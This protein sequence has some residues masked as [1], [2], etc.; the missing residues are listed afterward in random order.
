MMMLPHDALEKVKNKPSSIKSRKT[1]KTKTGDKQ[2]SI[3]V[4]T[5]EGVVEFHRIM[6][7]FEMCGDQAPESFAR[8]H[9]ELNM[10]WN[11]GAAL[12]FLRITY[13][14]SIDTIRSYA[15]FICK[16]SEYLAGKGIAQFG[17]VQPE[18]I[19]NYRADLQKPKKKRDNE[20]NVIRD[21]YNKVIKVTL[22]A[23][24]INNY[25]AILKSFYSFLYD[26]DQIKRDP[27]KILKRRLQVT[28][29][30]ARKTAKGKLTGHMTKVLTVDQVK[31]LL[32]NVG[33]EQGKSSVRNALLI[34]FLYKTGCRS[35]EAAQLTWK[36]LYNLG[37]PHE[38]YIYL[39]GKGAKEREVYVPFPLVE[40]LMKL[41]RELYNVPGFI[42]AKG[43]ADYP[44]FSKI[45]DR[46]EALGYNSI[47][48]IVRKWGERANLK[49]GL[50]QTNIS[51]HWLRH[52]FATHA[53]EAGYTLEEIQYVLGHESSS[54]TKIYAKSEHR[55]NPIGKMFEMAA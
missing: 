1:P 33:K 46:F 38:W 7:L 22:K 50:G 47:Y 11:E 20:G 13:A 40:K 9:P 26:M 49:L 44:I 19:T 24:T 3:V 30:Q 41:R 4:A 25:M 10:T 36:N 6:T 31:E 32:D 34:E 16:Y 14:G 43:L 8:N 52:T 55:K 53:L 37:D 45:N 48:T 12:Y 42:E 2:D 17:W 23:G 27:S 35:K 18:D 39:M 5:S 15:R 51:P 28:A 54:T 21:R 29:K